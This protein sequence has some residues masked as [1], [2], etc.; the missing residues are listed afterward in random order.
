MLKVRGPGF[1]QAG[2]VAPEVLSCDRGRA[3]RDGE[4][5]VWR[6]GDPPPGPCDRVTQSAR[7]G[8]AAGQRVHTFAE[9]SVQKQV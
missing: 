8:S 9:W 3:L 1:L 7:G 5:S 4:A 2:G 6:C